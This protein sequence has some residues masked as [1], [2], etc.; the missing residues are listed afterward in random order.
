VSEV[1]E[2][3]D[4][5]RGRTLEVRLHPA[6]GPLVVFAHGWV[7]HPDRFTRLLS[8]WQRSGLRVAAPVFP[9]SNAYVGE[10]SWEEMPEQ[11]RDLAFVA[12][13][14]GGGAPHALAGFSMGA[15]NV[16]DAAFAQ[17]LEPRPAAVVAMGGGVGGATGHVFDPLPL[18]VV[19]ATGD[20]VVPYEAAQDVFARASRPKALL[21]L[22]SDTHQEG[23]QDD[24]APDVSRVVDPATAGFLREA[25]AQPVSSAR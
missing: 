22:D 10:P 20:P 2:L 11:A 14:L 16:L 25:L 1:V 5:R 4:E 6:D 23:I 21:T 24:P 19:H 15:I 12:Q 18:L 8:H 17:R 7:G 3:H 13:A 9:R